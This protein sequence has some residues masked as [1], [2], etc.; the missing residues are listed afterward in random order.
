MEYLQILDFIV[1]NENDSVGISFQEFEQLQQQ[2]V[3]LKTE[4]YELTEKQKRSNK[5]TLK[6]KHS[7]QPLIFS[8]LELAELKQKLESQTQST[9]SNFMNKIVASTRDKKATKEFEQLQQENDK[10]QQKMQ[11]QE[12]DFQLQCQTLRTELKQ[13]QQD[14]ELLQE[15]VDQYRNILA[16]SLSEDESKKLKD[17][18]NSLKAENEKLRSGAP[19]PVKDESAAQNGDSSAELQELQRKLADFNETKRQ[20]EQ[21]KKKN[22]QLTANIEEKDGAL[23]TLAEQVASMDG[24]QSDVCENFKLEIVTLKKVLSETEAQ[25]IDVQKSGNE[26]LQSL[27]S[28]IEKLEKDKERLSSLLQE[29]RDSLDKSNQQIEDNKKSFQ[30]LED[31]LG[32]ALNDCKQIEPL[33]Q[34][35]AGLKDEIGEKEAEIRNLSGKVAKK[36]EELGAEV[37]NAEQLREKIA[38]LENDL[39]AKEEELEQLKSQNQELQTNCDDL[40][41]QF[42]QVREE[43][44]TKNAEMAKVEGSKDAII[45][46]KENEVE[47]LRKEIQR[48][49]EDSESLLHTSRRRDVKMMKDLQRQLKKEKLKCEQLT[50]RMEQLFQQNPMVPIESSPIAGSTSNLDVDHDNFDS[51]SVS[52]FSL[53][54]VKNA[55]FGGNSGHLNLSR[56]PSVT[57]TPNMPHHSPAMDHSGA[58]LLKLR[59]ENEQLREKLNHLEQAS[60][61]MADDILKKQE[62]IDHYLMSERE[63]SLSVTSTASMQPQNSQK[64]APVAAFRNFLDKVASPNP[65][66]SQGEESKRL[67]RAMEEILTK[68]MNLEADLQK[69]MEEISRLQKSLRSNSEAST[70]ST[71]TSTNN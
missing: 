14:K 2:I 6:K 29:T 45:K 40:K 48:V 46:E 18:V 59:N 42:D 7:F 54:N 43:N 26:N 51:S 5:G 32:K 25:L 21:V 69:A 3:T 58:D 19:V 34:K 37:S 16:N 11:S 4:N 62:L 1:M 47:E 68:N 35:I 12:I 44:E 64:P 8:I 55:I 38:S 61:S 9:G 17:E 50:E 67:R 36:E 22:E 30:K 39:L 57:S 15:N 53:S 70:T 56:A 27:Q 28:E 13:M 71:V 49:R 23:A 65:N 52:S 33:E 10:L 60:A 20:L 63:R 41:V 31:D 24:N 66:S